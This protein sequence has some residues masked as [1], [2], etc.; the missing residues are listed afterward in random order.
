MRRAT[1]LA[2]G[3]VPALALACGTGCGRSGGAVA[4]PAAATRASERYEIAERI[5]DG[6]L[7]PGWQDL[8][9]APHELTPGGPGH[10]DFSSGGWIVAK[11]GLSGTFGA[12]V[13]RVRYPPGE[14]EFL[15][16]RVDS[17]QKDIFPRV[18]ITA[19]DRLD[20]GDGWAEVLVPMAQLDPDGLPFDRVVFR[21]F[22]PIGHERF[23]MD[24]IALIK[25]DPDAGLL[26]VARAARTHGKPV[27]LLVDCRAVA[28]RIDPRIYGIAYY[29]N[30][31]QARRQQWTI[32]ATMRRWGGNTA[33]RYNWQTDAWNT[34]SDWYF[35]NV[36]T[37]P[38]RSFLDDDRAHH[39]GSAVVV[40]LIGWVAKDTTS[41]SFPVSVF[42]AQQSVDPWRKDAGNGKGKDG[43]ALPPGPPTRTS[44]E[45]PP[46]LVERWIESVV[47]A[48]AARGDGSRS[49]DTYILDNEPMLW[50]STHRDVHPEPV[51][52]DELLERTIA[53]GT[54]VRKADPQATIA[55]PA[56]WGWP[57]YSFS[58]VDQKAGFRNKPDRLAHGDQPLLPWYLQKL[59]EY[60]QKTGTRVLDLV[61]VHF[62]P[63]EDKVGT[64][65]VDR[66]TAA[67][68]VRSTRSLWDPTYVDESWIG[69]PIG[70]LPRLKEW[71]AANYPGRGIEIGEW[72]FG[73]E[74]HMSGGLAVAEALGRFADGG[75][76]AAYYWTCPPDGSPAYW[77]FRAFRDFDGKG[78][79]FLDFD[80]P[81]RGSGPE[82]SIFASRDPQ[83]KHL[84]AIL[85]NLSPDDVLDADVDLA[86]CGAVAQAHAYA[87]TGGPLGFRESP[88]PEVQRGSTTLTEPLPAYSMTVLDIV[89]DRPM[90]GA[91]SGSGSARR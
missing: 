8:G 68:R 24:K 66:G 56:L 26:P 60:E 3:V 43:S 17:P 46:E 90:T 55:G 76:T 11:P 65:A 58:A 6:G 4:P 5:Y 38:F 33:S 47:K 86:A 30:E 35:E 91:V 70:L 80:V 57:A 37:R 45:A 51:G 41:T 34:A 89:L 72:N 15:E 61:D 49:V 71:I 48:D 74:R 7:A 81:T 2:A 1:R 83:G 39:L 36:A 9:W 79:R 40:P 52:Y 18:K 73:G 28:A 44:V 85:L 29:A 14:A 63:Q 50:N 32:G 62:Y 54:A 13:F 64:D 23:E 88:P 10:F 20:L 25:P 69:E 12:L 53:Y 27:P 59:R 87:Y 19:D 75:V 22:R 77:A 67:L 78:G 82:A 16:V 42:G 84:V 21:A 31:D